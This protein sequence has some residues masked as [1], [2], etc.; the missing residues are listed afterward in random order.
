MY[1]VIKLNT[2]CTLET[3]YQND[4]DNMREICEITLEGCKKRESIP[5]GFVIPAKAGI[6]KLKHVEESALDNQQSLSP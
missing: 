2:F 5:G 1:P 6:Q 4:V 3:R